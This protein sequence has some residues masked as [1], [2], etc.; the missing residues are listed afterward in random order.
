[1]L[2][3]MS[4]SCYILLADP[5]TRKTIGL[6]LTESLKYSLL[7]RLNRGTNPFI[8]IYVIIVYTYSFI[9]CLYIYTIAY[10]ILAFTHG[11]THVNIDFLK[12]L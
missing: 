3:S 4:F 11:F 1:M 6:T 7:S 5:E 10:Y 12:Q 2:A 8:S 9:P